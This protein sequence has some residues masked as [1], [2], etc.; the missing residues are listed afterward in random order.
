MP[1]DA[2]PIGAV[3]PGAQNP[4]EAPLLVV[5]RLCT[6]LRTPQGLARVVDEVSFSLARKRVLAVVGESGSGKSMLARSIMG[7][8]PE[9]PGIRAGGRVLF[10][11]RDLLV[12]PEHEMRGIRG[13]DIAMVFQD[14]MTSLNPVLRVGEQIAEVVRHHL[15]MDRAAARARDL[16]LLTAVG[17]PMP[18]RR[19]DEYPHQLSGGLRQRVVIAIAL[20]CRPRLLIADEPTTALDVSIQAQILRLLKRYQRENDMAMIFVSHDLGTVAGIADD[21]AVMYAGR[22]VEYGPVAQVLNAPRMPYTEALLRSIPRLD[23]P[24]HGRLDAIRGRP[25]LLTALPAGCA[26][27]ARCRYAEP[28]C[29]TERPH[30]SGAPHAFACWFPCPTAAARESRA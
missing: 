7:L 3:R 13:R 12:L 25:P 24:S 20:A 14:P 5:D 28:R 15:G 26:F 4:P 1:A 29:A 27:Q 9:P 23:A 8:V 18:E 17:I 30:L 21:I 19:L 22:I 10:D 16:E 11:G 6:H 2:I